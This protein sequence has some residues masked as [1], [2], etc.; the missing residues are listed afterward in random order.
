M[1]ELGT[2]V[3]I[4]LQYGGVRYDLLAIASAKKR[5]LDHTVLIGYIIRID[6][7]VH[8]QAMA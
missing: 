6:Y 1:R 7:I 2:S 4:G 3:L 5:R 8:P